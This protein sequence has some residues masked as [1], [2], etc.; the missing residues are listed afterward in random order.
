MRA[1]ARARLVPGGACM[2]ESTQGTATATPLTAATA[3]PSRG[4]A[5]VDLELRMKMVERMLLAFRPERYAYL[6]LCV[7]A[8]AVLLWSSIQLLAKGETTQALAILG[9]SGVMAVALGRVLHMWNQA[10]RLIAGE[11][12]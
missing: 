11:K 1:A 10:F 12:P 9:S 5:S 3:P 6:L 4:D 2:T 7:I 8:C